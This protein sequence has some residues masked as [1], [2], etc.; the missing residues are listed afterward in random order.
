MG[1]LRTFDEVLNSSR[2]HETAK[3]RIFAARRFGV[4]FIP[5]EVMAPRRQGGRPILRGSLPPCG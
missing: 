5:G 2:K 4:M 1:P 3:T